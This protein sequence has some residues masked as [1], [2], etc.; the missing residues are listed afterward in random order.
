MT[1]FS[2]NFDPLST[3]GMSDPLTQAISLRDRHTIDM[4]KAA[5]S[6]KQTLLAFQPIVTAQDPT[7]VAFHEGLFRVLDNTGRIIPAKDFMPAVENTEV[8]RL[9][10]CAA[11]EMGLRELAENPDLRLSINMSARSIGYRKWT[12]ILDAYLTEHP[13]IGERLILEITERSAM[14]IPDLVVSFMKDLQRKGIAFALDD[15]GAGYTAFRYLKEFYFDIL[16]VDAIFTQGV[17]EDAGNQVICEAILSVGKHFDMVTV[18]EN[19]ETL[20]DAQFLTSAG[21]DCLQ[22]HLFGAPKTVPDW[23]ESATKQR[24]A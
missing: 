11:L 6:H 4:V 22:G 15:F 24:T 19:I 1:T 21:F 14:T 23:R 5:L 2:S 17:A 10:D 3:D 8:G 9:I 13:L 20:E 18:A 16:K 7:Q 12:S